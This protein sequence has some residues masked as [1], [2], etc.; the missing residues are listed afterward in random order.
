MA[1]I[2]RILS[3]DVHILN[4]EQLLKKVDLLINRK[5][6]SVISYVNAHAINLAYTNERFKT[7]LNSS[8]IVFCDGFGVRVAAKILG[9]PLPPR[10]SPPD[11]VEQLIDKC[12][13][14]GYSV[15]FLGA[16]PGTAAKMAEIFMTKYPSL[17]VRGTFH[18]FFDKTLFSK[19]NELVIKKINEG[20]PDILLIGF[21]MPA[22]EFWIEENRARLN[23]NVFMPVGAMMDYVTGETRRA[24]QCMTDHGFE[25]FGRLLIEPRRLWKRY[26][27]GIPI[28]FFRVFKALINERIRK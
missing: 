11:F 17:I 22:Q 13:T 16:K 9:Y 5:G 2:I 24:P 19:E 10:Y 1:E 28:F 27:L 26:I 21:G 25:W 23:V 12:A 7:F 18:G 3:V 6:S 20:S 4:L 8:D 15:F 14:S